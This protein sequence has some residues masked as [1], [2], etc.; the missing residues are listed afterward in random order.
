M[1]KFRTAADAGEAEEARAL[2]AVATKKLDKAASAGVIHRNQAANRK[3]RPSASAPRPSRRRPPRSRTRRR[4]PGAG[5][6][7]SLSPASREPAVPSRTRR[8]VRASLTLEHHPLQAYDAS[9]AAPLTSASA[10]A[11][12][13]IAVTRPRSSQPRAVVAQHPQL[14]RRHPGLPRQVGL[15]QA[16]RAARRTCRARA[17]RSRTRSSPG[18]GRCRCPAPSAAPPA[19]PPSARRGRVRDRERLHLGPATEVA[20]HDRLGQRLTGEVAGQRWAAPASARR[21]WPI[22][23]TSRSAASSAIRPP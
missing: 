9:P 2:A 8:T 23:C 19:R 20:P 3:P 13:T 22:A 4:S 21:S 12:A 5:A 16:A 6:S 15:A 10:W 14:P 17:T 18:S 11:T 7:S 1:R